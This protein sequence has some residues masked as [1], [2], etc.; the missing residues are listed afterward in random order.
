MIS[1]LAGN[2]EIVRFRFRLAP[3]PAFGTP[4]PIWKG[5]GVRAFVTIFCNPHMAREKSCAIQFSAL[6]PG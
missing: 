1:T 4:L 2:R 5:A 6:F 3:H